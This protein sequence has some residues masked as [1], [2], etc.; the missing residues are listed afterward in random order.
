MPIQDA[1]AALGTLRAKIRRI[2][3]HGADFGRECVGFGAKALDA[4]LPWQGIPKRSLHELSG[5]AADG[6]AAALASRALLGVGD[7]A[8]GTLLWCSQDAT[9]RISGEIYGPGLHRFGI[10][11]ERFLLV[12]ARNARESLWVTETALR[13]QAIVCVV[14]EL[15]PLDLLTSRRLQLAAEEGGGLGLAL[16]GEAGAIPDLAPN[17]AVT[18]W[19]VEPIR[20]QQ[21]LFWQLDLWRCRGGA[22]GRWEVRWNEPTLSFSLA[23]EAAART[24]DAGGKTIRQAAF[25]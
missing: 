7:Q 12:R 15:P 2:E 23:A 21:E 13:S 16:L 10:P 9:R 3:G 4:A 19:R 11:A 17:A 25:A 20:R 24:A 8:R 5:I 1:A 22:P 6:F 18:R 14:A